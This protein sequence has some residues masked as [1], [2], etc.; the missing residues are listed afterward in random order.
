MPKRIK[1]GVFPL[2]RAAVAFGFVLAIA[3]CGETPLE[4]SVLGAGGGALGAAVLDVD[5]TTGAL[6]GALANV[7]YC[8]RHP[9]EC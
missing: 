2:G 8:Q 4:Q 6:V 7:A 1:P 9:E 3:G 5:T